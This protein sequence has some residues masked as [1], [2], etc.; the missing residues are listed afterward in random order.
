MGGV[1]EEEHLLSANHE[2]L[3]RTS[4]CSTAAHIEHASGELRWSNNKSHYGQGS[5][6]RV[7]LWC[8]L[9]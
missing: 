1:V 4:L 9:T 8:C 7:S 6:F 2:A 5:S 3:G